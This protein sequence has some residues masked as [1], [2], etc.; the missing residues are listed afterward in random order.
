M[1]FRAD[2]KG[3]TPKQAAKNKVAGLQFAA[4]RHFAHGFRRKLLRCFL[5]VV[6]GISCARSYA[7]E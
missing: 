3:A 2:L 1:S 6:S 4:C 7:T 5:R